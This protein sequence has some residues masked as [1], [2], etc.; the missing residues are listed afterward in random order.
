[1]EKSEIFAKEIALIK[2]KTLQR[3]TRYYLDNWT[4][5]IFWT[6]GASASGKFHPDFA[7]GEGGLVR[8]TKA[9]VMFCDEL[10]KMSQ[11]A[12]MTDARKDIAIMACIFHDTC[13]YGMT[14]E[15]NTAEYKNHA[16]NAAVNVE[17]AWNEYFDR[18]ND[19]RV[20]Y[21]YE[22]MQAIRSH[23]GQWS[24][25]RDDRPFTPVDRLV[26][27]AD[28]VASRN[29]LSIPELEVTGE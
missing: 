21:P 29:F 17:L 13:K 24:T 1:M 12:Y 11:W 4:P 9:V 5:D 18:Y 10:M 3:F 6:T 7:K 27:L 16:E 28:Y 23:M 8:H 19:P 2:D 22:L 26:H 25:N 14:N 20:K 15:V